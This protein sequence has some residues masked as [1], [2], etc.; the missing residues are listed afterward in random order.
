MELSVILVIVGILVGAIIGGQHLMHTVRLNKV[1]EQKETFEAGFSLFA[2]RYRELPGDMRNATD[3]WGAINDTEHCLTPR[4]TRSGNN[5]GVGTGTE[6]C[7]GDSNGM[8][9]DWSSVAATLA[10]ER[11]RAWQH[12]YNAGIVHTAYTGH[13][14]STGEYDAEPDRN[15]PS[16]PFNSSGWSVA[17]IGDYSGSSSTTNEFFNRTYGNLLIFGA[18]KDGFP[19]MNPILTPA[20]A[21][22][23]EA[24]V[25]DKLPDRGNVTA[26][27]SNTSPIS[28]C[29]TAAG[30]S[31]G[32]GA[33]Y[34]TDSE[35]VA[36]A[37]Y[38]LLP[39]DV[40][41]Q[42]TDFDK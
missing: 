30:N 3:Y 18:E 9:G 28:L 14:G 32:F 2:E 6:T 20:E 25:D 4:T 1:L 35:E 13:R 17:R 34:N 40:R 8:I 42:R 33:T 27:L 11:F 15:V 39:M 29:T 23:I 24:K 16:G 21:F 36:C 22:N 26:V 10:H 37:L 12:L 41:G 19:T 7:N 31:T 5:I 38:F